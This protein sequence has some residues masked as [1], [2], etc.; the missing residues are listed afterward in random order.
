[1]TKIFKYI[2]YDIWERKIKVPFEN[3]QQLKDC[4]YLGGFYRKN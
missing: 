3:M 4:L 2:K 1:M